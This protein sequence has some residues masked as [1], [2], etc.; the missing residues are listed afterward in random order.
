M[1][2]A[3][4]IFYISAEVHKHLITENYNSTRSPSQIL[5][6][7]IQERFILDYFLPFLEFESII[8]KIILSASN[9]QTDQNNIH[10]IN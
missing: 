3:T 10:I 9:C 4:V 5:V 6:M 7:Q 8:L 1:Q 2:Q